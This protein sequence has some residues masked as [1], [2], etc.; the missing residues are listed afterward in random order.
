MRLAYSGMRE[1]R[2]VRCV[3]GRRPPLLRG[4][5]I[6]EARAICRRLRCQPLLDRADAAEGAEPRVRA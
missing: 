5:A 6:D 3:S 1:V 4:L 2:A